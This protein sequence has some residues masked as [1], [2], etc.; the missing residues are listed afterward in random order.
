MR[1]LVNYLCCTVQSP[2]IEQATNLSRVD[3]LSLDVTF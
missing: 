2:Q 1:G 3:R